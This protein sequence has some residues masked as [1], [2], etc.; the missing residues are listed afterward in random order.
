MQ[1][2]EVKPDKFTFTYLINALAKKRSQHWLEEMRKAG[3]KPAAVVF[4]SLIDG[5]EKIE[6][7]KDIHQSI[8]LKRCRIE[9]RCNNVE[10][11]LLQV[12]RCPCPHLY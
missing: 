2:D 4:Y 12:A 5:M 3:A 8:G 6:A 1:N 7:I 9:T 10:L 11:L